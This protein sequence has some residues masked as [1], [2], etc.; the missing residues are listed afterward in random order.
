MNYEVVERNAR[1]GTIVIAVGGGGIPVFI[2][3]KGDVRPSEAVIDK[4]LASALLANQIKADEF[5]MLTDVPFVFAN[6]GSPNER[7]L[8]FLD[9]NEALKYLEAGTFGEGS[10]APKIKAALSFIEQD[11]GKCIITESKKLEDKSY[12]T[13]ITMHYDEKDL[14]KYGSKNN[15]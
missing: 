12:G 1:A 9:Y 8:E 7:K 3:E 13:K 14:D 10:M 5:Y 2:D 4:D 15:Q 11:G 6:F